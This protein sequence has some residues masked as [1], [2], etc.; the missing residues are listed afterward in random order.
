MKAREGEKR[1]DCGEASP[2]LLSILHARFGRPNPGFHF[3]SNLRPSHSES[4]SIYFPDRESERESGLRSHGRAWA[5]EQGHVL[6]QGLAARLGLVQTPTLQVALWAF[7]SPS[8]HAKWDMDKILKHGHYFAA[9]FIH[10][11]AMCCHA[12][13]PKL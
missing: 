2:S 12:S 1:G 3:R 8:F 4:Q 13:L 7:L 5:I 10:S 6:F 9:I 11:V